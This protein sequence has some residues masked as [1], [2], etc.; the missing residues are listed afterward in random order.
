MIDRVD[1]RN[2]I[3]IM[4]QSLDKLAVANSIITFAFLPITGMP[5]EKSG[6]ELGQIKKA[7]KSSKLG[8]WNEIR[9]QE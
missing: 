5:K 2:I 7:M 8:Q 6:T 4:P 3:Y 1:N 9:V